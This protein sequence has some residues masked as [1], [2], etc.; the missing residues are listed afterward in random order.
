MEK[1]IKDIFPILGGLAIGDGIANI[2]E[3]NMLGIPELIVG[4]LA[5][6]YVS[7]LILKK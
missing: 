7:Y 5:L 2:Y 6:S 1:V 4:V 3:N